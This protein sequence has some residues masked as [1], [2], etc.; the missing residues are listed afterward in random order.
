MLKPFLKLNTKLWWRSLQG[1]E[2]AAILFYSLFIML[3]VGQFLGVILVLLF[4]TDIQQAQSLYS[5]VTPEIQKFFHLM[6]VNALWISQVFFTK[7][8][9][10]RLHDNRK[11]LALGFP[12]NKLSNYLNTAGFFHPVN[13][14]FQFFWL[15]YL[16][17]QAASGI[18]FFAVTMLILVNYGL[19]N[20]LKWRFRIYFADKF[21]HVGGIALTL[22]ILIVILAINIDF[23]TY[24]SSPQE[25]AGTILG[26][27][28]F[29]PGYIFYYVATD[30]T[31][32]F[33]QIFVLFILISL[34]FMLNRD[35]F[36]NTKSALLTPAQSSSKNLKKSRLTNFIKWLGHEGGKYFYSVWSH[37]YSKI[38]LLIT[39]VFV[40]PYIILLGDGTYII[41]V[42]LTLIPI[43]FLMVLMTNMFGFE[44]RELLLSVQLPIE[45]S[46]IVRQRIYTALLVT[47]GGSAIVLIAVPVFIDS[48]PVMIQIHLGIILIALIFLHY[49]LNS[50]VNNY[51]KIE[52]VSVM[53]VSNPVLPASITF[54]SVFIVMILG[55]FTFLVIKNYI[56]YHILTL[57]ILNILLV[58][59]FRKKMNSMAGLFK[60]KVI[61]KLWNEL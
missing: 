28:Y 34:L 51:N 16:G 40:F 55:L 44:N 19:I 10:L 61:P 12:V 14:M 29:T 49:I 20:S 36:M 58:I 17:F 47:L 54:T 27:L 31:F 38:Q 25:A 56:W 53:S 2:V 43:I 32:R 22:V 42:F 3:V 18:Q 39:Y 5:W 26:Y 37:K 45:S 11:L 35:M 6:F 50:S 13:L 48:I 15:T 24:I 52:E 1:L 33:E 57:L 41:G 30:L 9:R 21:R 4:T 8:N 23:T 59:S 7:I 60:Q 46:D